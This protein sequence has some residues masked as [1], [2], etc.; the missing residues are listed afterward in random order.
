MGHYLVEGT[1][2]AEA[3]KALIASPSD[4]S[5]VAKT[6]V[7]LMGGTFH[8]YFFKSGQSGYVVL[9]ELPDENGRGGGRL[10]AELKRGILK[11]F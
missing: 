11:E 1:F 8:H 9:C 2:A 3:S 7:E 5:A 10:R 4:R 6:L